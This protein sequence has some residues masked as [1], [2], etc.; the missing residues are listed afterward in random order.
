MLSIQLSSFSFDD[1]SRLPD[2]FCGVA[3]NLSPPLQ[4]SGV[5]TSA[6]ELVITCVDHTARPGPFV[7]WSVA[8]IDPSIVVCDEGLVPSGSIEGA[9]SRGELG[10]TGPFPPAGDPPHDYFFRVHALESPSKLLEGFSYKDLQ[11]VLSDHEIATG[12]TLGTYQR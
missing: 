1:H 8:R 10:Y 5:P 11:Q 6:I 7:H 12:T 2:R 4:W 9:N 3:E